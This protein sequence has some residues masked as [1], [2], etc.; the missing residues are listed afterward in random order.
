MP[1]GLP[2]IFR[3]VFGIFGVIGL[4]QSLAKELGPDNIRVNAVLPGIVEGPRMEKVIRD[5]AEA[6]GM[7]YAAMKDDYLNN[8]SMRRMVT[9]E[10]VAATMPALLADLVHRELVQRFELL[11][12]VVLVHLPNELRFSTDIKGIGG[13]HL[14]AI[15]Q[16]K[17]FN[18]GFELRVSWPL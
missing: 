12:L 9:P 14:H 16:L 2:I 17:G 5:R 10:D 13:I 7:G 3:L 15:G 8:I 11:P 6:T 1:S 4:T 18:A